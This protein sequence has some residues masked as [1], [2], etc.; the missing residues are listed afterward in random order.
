[1]THIPVVKGPDGVDTLICADSN[2]WTMELTQ[3]VCDQIGKG[4]WVGE[5]VSLYHLHR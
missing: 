1:M 5:G 2:K 3:V 4:K